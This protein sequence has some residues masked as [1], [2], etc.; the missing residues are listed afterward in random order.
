MKWLIGIFLCAV[1]LL[2]AQVMEEGLASYYHQRLHG[3]QTASGKLY[4][5]YEFVGAHRTLPFGTFVRI[6]NL[7]NMKSVIVEITDRGP[8][9]RDRIID[10]SY[11]AALALDFI[12]KGITRVRIEVVPGPIDYR[13]LEPIYPDIKLFD[14]K[15]I[16]EEDIGK[17][18]GDIESFIF[19]DHF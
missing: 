1:P 14:I 8:R 6:T 5:K 15:K 3:K 4:N 2:H 13:Y 18:K 12:R 19:S 10:V 7:D 16:G 17:Y 9:R 11:N